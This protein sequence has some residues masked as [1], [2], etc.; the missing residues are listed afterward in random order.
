MRL[1]TRM[2]SWPQYLLPQKLL[3]A[4]AWKLSNCRAPWFKNHF[5]SVFVQLF[6]VNLEEAERSRPEDYEC[7]NDFFTRALKPGARKLADDEHLLISPCDGTIS[8]LGPIVN[9]TLIQAKGIDYHAAAL[10]GSTEWAQRFEHGRFITIYLAPNDYHRVH[11]PISGR[12]IAETRIPGSLFS[13]SA[14]T[15][16]AVSGLF[17]RNERMAAMFETAHGPVAV[18]MVAAL[19]V[20]GIESV[21]DGP[22]RRRPTRKAETRLHD[23]IEIERGAEMGRFHWGSTVILLTPEGFPPWREPLAGGRRIRLGQPLTDMPPN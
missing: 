7:F 1:A 17:T 22:D 13:V 18:V 8:Q 16:L 14:A 5:I 4:I 20:A 2:L 11:M 6:R 21:W 9:G 3:T 15:T 19:M 10:L 23:S 12:L